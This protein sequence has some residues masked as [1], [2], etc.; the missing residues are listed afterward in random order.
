MDQTDRMI[1]NEIQ[2]DFPIVPQPYLELGKRLGLAEQE[3]L[4]RVKRLKAEGII[5]RIGGNFSSRR[6]KFSSTLCAAKVPEEKMA[7]FV[8]AVNSYPGVTHNY[9]RNHEYNVWFTFIA[10]TTAYIEDALEEISR[11]TGVEE[12][13][14]LPAVRTFK[15]KVD[16]E[17]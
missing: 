12:I 4:D 9:L 10:P 14:N 11:S 16:F 3:V 5:R 1:L 17:V 15:I 13:R 6:L 7:R 2:S 8:E